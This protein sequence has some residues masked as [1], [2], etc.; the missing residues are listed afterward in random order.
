MTNEALHSDRVVMISW[1]H[2]IHAEDV[3]R[4]TSE[5]NRTRRL[6]GVPLVVILSIAKNT[7]VASLAV[8]AELVSCLPR[9][10]AQCQKLLV[11][12][13]PGAVGHR[14][15]RAFFLAHSVG[16]GAEPCL[17]LCDSLG[18]AFEYAQ[19]VAPHEVLE[20]QRGLLQFGALRR[21]AG[22]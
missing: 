17:Q 1:S 15:I 21:R 11:A 19:R 12:S 3:L 9:I 18:Q 6:V 10:L 16:G 20:L 8:Q 4:L 2:A 5:V 13:E 22:S 7:A 14:L